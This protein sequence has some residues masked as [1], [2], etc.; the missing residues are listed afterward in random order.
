MRNSLLYSQSVRIAIVVAGLTVSSCRSELDMGHHISPDGRYEAVIRGF[1]GRGD[2]RLVELLAKSGSSDKRTVFYAGRVAASV[3]WDSPTSLLL[4]YSDEG[5]DIHTVR[6]LLEFRTNGGKLE[7]IRVH[8]RP[9]VGV[10]PPELG[11]R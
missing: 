6:T 9:V 4:Y 11:L 2:Y 1:N 8:L 5:A 10:A 3:K 7:T